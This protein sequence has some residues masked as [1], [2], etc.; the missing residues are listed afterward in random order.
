MRSDRLNYIGATTS[1]AIGT[2]LVIASIAKQSRAALHHTG[3]AR[4]ARNDGWGE[5]SL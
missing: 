3:L 1:S 4:F 2:T 5:Q